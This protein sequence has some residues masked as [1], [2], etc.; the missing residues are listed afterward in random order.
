MLLYSGGKD[1]T[2]A[3]YRLYNAGYNV[4]FIHFNNGYMCDE[5]K[6]YLTFQET[7]DKEKDFY[8]DY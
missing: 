6:P 2:L 8:F 4:H 5:D 3:A 1:S 7:F